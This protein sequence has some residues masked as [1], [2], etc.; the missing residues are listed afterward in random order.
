[1]FQPL[2]QRSIAN[3]VHEFNYVFYFDKTFN[4]YYN[5]YIPLINLLSL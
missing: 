3:A 1:M 2:Q 5:I 4:Y